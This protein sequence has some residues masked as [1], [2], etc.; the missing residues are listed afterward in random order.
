MLGLLCLRLREEL[1]LVKVEVEVAQLQDRVWCNV[2]VVVRRQLPGLA[3][4][5]WHCVG[6]QSESVVEYWQDNQM[7]RASMK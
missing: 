4:N 2:G 5:Y 1:E 6:K 7:R 3:G